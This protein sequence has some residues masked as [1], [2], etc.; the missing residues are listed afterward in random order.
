METNNFVP[1]T[2]AER[3]MEK[4]KACLEIARAQHEAA[5]QQHLSADKLGELGFVLELSAVE[6]EGN[7]L[8]DAGHERG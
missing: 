3:L 4:A 1:E 5:G 6:I 2:P 8:M 7:A